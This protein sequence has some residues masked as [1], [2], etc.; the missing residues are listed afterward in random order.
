MKSL[1]E[2]L[3]DSICGNV[4]SESVNP[5]IKNFLKNKFNAIDKFRKELFKNKYALLKIQFGD[6]T[7]ILRG[8]YLD[9]FFDHK[10]NLYEV[11]IE[12]SYL[13][14]TDTII[15]VEAHKGMTQDTLIK[16]IENYLINF[17]W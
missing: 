12:S 6:D 15:R 11:T 13:E 7:L 8:E 1:M 17:E 3:I 16:A 14:K 9:M 5:E 10:P 4:L 2:Y